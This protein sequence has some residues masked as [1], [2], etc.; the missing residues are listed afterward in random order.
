MIGKWYICGISTFLKDM[1]IYVENDCKD[2]W[3]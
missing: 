3:D 2:I 1:T